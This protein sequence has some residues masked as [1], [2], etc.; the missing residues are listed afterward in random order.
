M[1]QI[2]LARSKHLASEYA[3]AW[4][5]DGAL[6]ALRGYDLWPMSSRC[7]ASVGVML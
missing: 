5:A 4:F 6:E 1:I 7:T 3:H 2:N